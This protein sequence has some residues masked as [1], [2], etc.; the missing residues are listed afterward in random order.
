MELK[1]K[2]EKKPIKKSG[3]TNRSISMAHLKKDL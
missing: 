2:L 3:E 1:E